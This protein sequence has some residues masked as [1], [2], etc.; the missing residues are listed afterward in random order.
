MDPNTRFKIL[1][2]QWIFMFWMPI[3]SFYLHYFL[4][5]RRFLVRKLVYVYLAVSIVILGIYYSGYSLRGVLSD[6]LINMFFYFSTLNILWA[7]IRSH[8]PKPLKITVIVL[9]IGFITGQG[10][11][12]LM[13]KHGVDFAIPGRMPKSVGKVDNDHFFRTFI[14]ENNNEL[15]IVLYRKGSGN[16]IWE[17]RLK[18]TTFPMNDIHLSK[19]DIEFH[20]DGGKQLLLEIKDRT[21]GEVLFLEKSEDGRSSN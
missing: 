16:T 20:M 5:N 6:Q 8:I 15:L 17:K 1:L 13:D 21:T 7:M 9:L 18:S 4:L 12:S 19:L 10:L 2:L 11:F 3:L 14:Y